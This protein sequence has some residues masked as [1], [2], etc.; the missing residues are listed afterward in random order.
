MGLMKTGIP[1]LDEVFKGGILEGSSVLVTGAPGTGKTIFALQFIAEGLRNKEPC[2]YITSEESAA[3]LRRYAKEIGAEIEKHEDGL[4]QIYEQD[5]TSRKILSLEEPLNAIKTRGI[6]RI[7]LDSLTLFEYVYYESK[8]DFRKGILDFIKHTKKMGSTL[9]ATSEKTNL[10]IDEIKF[11]AQ[12]FI[13][14]GLV[15]LTMIRKGSM[16]ERCIHIPKMRGQ[17]H[18]LDIFP[19]SITEKGMVVHTKQIPFSLIE[20]DVMKSRR[21]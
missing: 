16:F 21:K 13:F 11:S 15:H 20:Q 14:E 9:L 6:K 10:E 18:L 8:I 12:D 1:G 2:L 17:D 19:M 3:S 4:L 5:L 7:V